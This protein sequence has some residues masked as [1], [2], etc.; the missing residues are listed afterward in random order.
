MVRKHLFSGHA[1]D[2]A[3][4]HTAPAGGK[5][6]GVLA[7]RCRG[8][9]TG[10]APGW[11]STQGAR[12]ILQARQH[13]ALSHEAILAHIGCLWCGIL[14][15]FQ[16]R[17]PCLRHCLHWLLLTCSQVYL[18]TEQIAARVCTLTCCM[19]VIEAALAMV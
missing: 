15:I 14:H 7:G 12:A 4:L 13:S 19:P 17:A 6:A 1:A 11:G 2:G 9:P 3:I 10:H 16:G 5:D 18:F 8:G